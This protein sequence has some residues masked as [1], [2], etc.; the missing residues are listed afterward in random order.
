MP[1]CDAITPELVL[2][3][4]SLRARL[5]AEGLRELERGDEIQPASSAPV[6]GVDEPAVPQAAPSF[7]LAPAAEAPTVTRHEHGHLGLI[8]AAPAVVFLVLVPLLAFL[9]PR[10]APRLVGPSAEAG[11]TAPQA[12]RWAADPRAN[13]YVLRIFRDRRLVRRLVASRP[14]AAVAPLPNG[15]YSWDVYAGYGRVADAVTRGPI[16]DPEVPGGVPL[17]HKGDEPR[18]IS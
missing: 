16:A 6:T 10:Q 18:R 14:T 8:A 11:V 2:V 12:L 7:T 3:D 5:Q 13:Y 9:P 17:P 15:V 1:S 4:P